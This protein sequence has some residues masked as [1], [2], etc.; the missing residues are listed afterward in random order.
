[1]TGG[2]HRWSSSRQY[3]VSADGPC[4]RG[5]AYAVSAWISTDAIGRSRIGHG[6][7]QDL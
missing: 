7:L 1:M 4:F 2:F 5:S 3:G 6:G